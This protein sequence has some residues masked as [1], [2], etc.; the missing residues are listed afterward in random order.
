MIQEE[1][2]VGEIQVDALR[3]ERVVPGLS[4]AVQVVFC[5]LTKIPEAS[6]IWDGREF[7]RRILCNS[8]SEWKK[9]SL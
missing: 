2:P 9:E 5:D 8:F 3:E 6:G 1:L 7:A 4:P